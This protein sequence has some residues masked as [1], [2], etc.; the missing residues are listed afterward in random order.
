MQ[1]YET[2]YLP[3]TDHA[4]IA[5]HTVVEKQLWKTDKV[6]RHDIGRPAFE[7]KLWEW[8]NHNGNTIQTQ[9]RKIG[10]S[11]DWSRYRFTMDD[12]LSKGVI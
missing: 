1:G 6:T 10:A 12:M 3:G 5:T 4:G 9:L 11:L 2:L 8:V 7:K